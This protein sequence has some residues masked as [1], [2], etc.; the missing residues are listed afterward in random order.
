MIVI[1]MEA[2]KVMEK[3]QIKQ[4]SNNKKVVEIS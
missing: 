2:E 3:A 1:Q 4:Q